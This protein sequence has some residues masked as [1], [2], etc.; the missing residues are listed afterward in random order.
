M[1]FKIKFSFKLYL[2]TKSTRYRM[3]FIRFTQNA[4]QRLRRD[5]LSPLNTSEHIPG[6]STAN[7]GG[8]EILGLGFGPL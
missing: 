5:V 4:C 7:G 3:G 8:V 6:E 2:F 1:S